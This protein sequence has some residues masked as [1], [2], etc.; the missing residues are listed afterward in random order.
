[1]Y[2]VLNSARE[3]TQKLKKKVLTANYV[4][5]SVLVTGKRKT[6]SAYFMQVFIFT[7]PFFL[8]KIALDINIDCTVRFQQCS[9]L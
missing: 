5:Q 4:Q 8:F 9:P 1:M 7:S 6:G 3:N 2:A